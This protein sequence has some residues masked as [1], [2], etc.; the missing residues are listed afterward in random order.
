MRHAEHRVA[1]LLLRRVQGDGAAMKPNAP[2]AWV[3]GRTIGPWGS[4]CRAV[5]GVVAIVLAVAIP[6]QH[7]L[8]DLPGSRSVPVGLLLGVIGLPAATTLVILVRGRA[9]PRVHLGRGAACVI[10]ALL[11]VAALIY[12]VVILVGIGAPLVLQAAIGRRGCELMAVSNLLLRR[13]DY[14]FCLPFSPIDN[15][16]YRRRSGTVEDPT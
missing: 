2:P 16:E 12:P 1:V 8:F 14:L 13:H 5:A 4:V 11:V 15:W 9:A 7:P 10:T 6:Y 3:A